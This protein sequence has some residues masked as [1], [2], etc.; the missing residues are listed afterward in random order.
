VAALHPGYEQSFKARFDTWVGTLKTNPGTINFRLSPIE[1]LF[2]GDQAG[3][4]RRAA[5]A[6]VDS[7][8]QVVSERAESAILLN[9]MRLEMDTVGP[10]ATHGV[11]AMISDPPHA[12]P[13]SVVRIAVIDGDTLQPVHKRAYRIANRDFTAV[14]TDMKRYERD[15]KY[16]IAITL[17]GENGSQYFTN[18]YSGVQFPTGDFYAFLIGCGGGAAVSDWHDKYHYS[19]ADYSDRVTLAFVGSCGAQANSG[20][21]TLGHNQGVSNRWPPRV[22][23]RVFLRPVDIGNNQIRFRP[24]EI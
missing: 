22:E 13:S 4:V 12:Y 14:M 9:G 21:G 10:P 2:S 15:S 18:G 16:I 19:S 23:A 1:E 24:E 5:T 3:H 11:D 20:I 8:L 6:Y 17:G 7:Q